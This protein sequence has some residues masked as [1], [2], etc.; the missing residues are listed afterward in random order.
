MSCLFDMLLNYDNL[1]ISSRPGMGDTTL[2]VNIA[3]AYLNKNTDG[4]IV[5]FGY[6]ITSTR[7]IHFSD[8]FN[9][10]LLARK[11]KKEVCELI[12]AAKEGL[13]ECDKAP[14]NERI[15][16]FED[17][18][19]TPEEILEKVRAIDGVGLVFL[20]APLFSGVAVN[21]PADYKETEGL[22]RAFKEMGIKFYWVHAL[23]KRP[24]IRT[25]FIPRRSHF[26][27]EH[28]LFDAAAT[29]YREEYYVVDDYI[30]IRTS[31]GWRKIRHKFD[32]PIIPNREEIIIYPKGFKKAK[33]FKVSFDFAHQIIEEK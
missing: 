27:K 12:N 21:R 14:Q 11:S 8:V 15:I 10:K 7:G 33:T 19:F 9:A 1:F 25:Y 16:Y 24:I 26:I 30:K 20:D 23:L 6:D 2:I 29:L 28:K 13:F 22:V 17:L 4:K 18:A 32:S 3:D 31:Y 5:I